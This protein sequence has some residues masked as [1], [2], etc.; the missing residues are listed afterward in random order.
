MRTQASRDK[1][2]VLIITN[3]TKI[4][5]LKEKEDHKAVDR[6]DIFEVKSCKNLNFLNDTKTANKNS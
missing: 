1:A 5:I 3:A 6:Y 2:E 4:S